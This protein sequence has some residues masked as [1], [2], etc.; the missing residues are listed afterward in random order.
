MATGKDIAI[1]GAG[2]GGLAAA[3]AL[4]RAGQ[5][6]TVFERFTA[7]RPVGSG[8]MLQPTGLA[9]LERLGLREPMAALGAPI[10]RLHGVT[11]RGRTVFDLAYADLDPTLYALAV[12]RAALHGV[13]WDGFAASEAMLEGGRTIVGTDVQSGDRVGVIDAAGRMTGNFDLVVDASGVRSALRALVSRGK[14][15]P[16]TYGA[17]W[18]NVPDIGFAPHT[19]AQ[20]Y[21]AARVM[22]GYL[23]AGRMVTEIGRAH[24]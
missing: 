6:V 5:R 23:P 15:R 20:R 24:V 8:L 17:V 11:D 16:F 9:A 12:H 13:L 2:I 1:V 18:A 3:I 21:V 7:P 14:M 4:R 10:V 19:L 22:V